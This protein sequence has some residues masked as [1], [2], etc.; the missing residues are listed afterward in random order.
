ML[1]TPSCK[2]GEN[3]PFISF[4][5]RKARVAGDWQLTGL[6]FEGVNTEPDGDKQTTTRS[7]VDGVITQTYSDFDAGSG[8]TT[9]TITKTTINTATYTMA[10]DGTW[11]QVYNTTSV[12]SSSGGGFTTTS[13]TIYTST[14]SGNWSFIGKAKGEYKSRERVMMN[15]ITTTY[16]WQTTTVIS[17]DAG[18]LADVVSEG[19]HNEYV[20]N[21]SSGQVQETWDVDQL[22]NKEMII[23]NTNLFGGSWTTTPAGAG[24]ITSGADDDYT[25]TETITLTT[26]K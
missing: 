22:K 12:T 13:T 18:V 8:T 2:K 6:E 7:L 16:A 4:S 9:T 26:V 17:D 25:S 21:Y 5:S 24:V 10:K 1:A 15:T 20:D 19:D 11:S 23:I 14:S 3:D